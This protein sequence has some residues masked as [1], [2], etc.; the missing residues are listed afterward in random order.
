LKATPSYSNQTTTTSTASSTH[1]TDACCFV[2]QDTVNEIWW[3]ETSYSST[4]NVVNLTS[5]TTFL[6]PFPNGTSTRVETN[7]QVT[8][9]SFEWTFLVGIN[10]ITNYINNAPGPTEAATSLNGT[11]SSVVTGGVT[12]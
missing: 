9:A 11:V 7:I 6:T 4:Y 12:V 1:T 3:Q 2:V 10:P 5:F 8:N